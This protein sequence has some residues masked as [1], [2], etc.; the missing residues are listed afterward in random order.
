M[1]IIREFIDYDS[2]PVYFD[3]TR[4]KSSSIQVF[5]QHNVP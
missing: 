2:V 5:I 1:K 3:I 4:C